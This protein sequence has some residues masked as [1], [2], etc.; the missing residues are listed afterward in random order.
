LATR[1]ILFAL[2]VAI[3]LS[4]VG[5]LRHAHA[6]ITYSGDI[7]GG[8]PPVVSDPNTWTSSTEAYIGNT[9]DGSIR[10]D[11][12]SK[13]VSSDS[14]L[15][16]AARCRGE[17]TVDGV[18]S[19]WTSS[20]RIKVGYGGNGVLNV[21]NGGYV[22]DVSGYVGGHFSGGAGTGAA[23]VSGAYSTW[24]NS[25]EL[26]VGL[27]GNGTLDI[28][29]GGNVSNAAGY[30]GGYVTQNSGVSSNATGIVTVAGAGSTWTNSSDLFVGSS[31][32]GRLNI[33][34]GGAVNS[35]NSYVGYS[36]VSTGVVTVD[37][38]GSTWNH[39]NLYVGAGQSFPSLPPTGGSG[40]LEITNGGRV[41][42]HAGGYLGYLAGSTGE[43]DVKG[44]GSKWT[45]QGDTYVGYGGNG[46]LNVTDGG[47]ISSSSNTSNGYIGY[48]AG[49]TG[50]VTLNG[51]AS[52][53]TR[54]K[55]CV[56]DAGNGTLNIK[57]GSAVSTQNAYIGDDSTS[58]GLVTVD[59]TG[60]TWNQSA[61]LY[62][63]KSGAGTLNITNGG[64]VAVGSVSRLVDSYIGSGANSSGVVT[65][66][67]ANSKWTNSGVLYVG[68]AGNGT[69]S[70][71][72]GGTVR[73]ISGGIGQD[74]DA[75]GI[76][77]VSG[78]GS[79]WTN[80]N[81]LHVG[82]YGSGA[83][84]VLNGGGVSNY[85]GYIG[86]YF[87]GTGVATVDGAGSTW[88]NAGALDVG[89]MGS[90]TLNVTNHGSV[91]AISDTRVAGEG[92]SAT[93]TINFGANGG[94]LTTGSLLASPN[95]L[96]GVGT[97][98]T[99]GLV[100]DV[101]LVFDSAAS[102]NQTL[103]LSNSG[104][105]VA[106]N[107]NMA[108]APS[109]NGALGAGYLGGGSLT[110]KN[111]AAVQSTRGYLGYKSGST[112]AAT[113]A[114]ANSTWANSSSLRVG[115][116]GS[117]QLTVTNGGSVSN[118]IGWVGFNPM[119]M[120]TVTVNGAGST[121]TNTEAL[122]VG[123]GGTG[124]LRIADGGMVTASSASINSSSLL[125]MDV[126]RGSLLSV[127]NGTSTIT[128]NGT[129]RVVAGAGIGAGENYSPIS[130]SSWTGTGVYQAIG[131]TWNA[132]DHTFTASAVKAG[133]SG[134]AVTVN[135]A[136]QQRALIT[137]STTRWAAG[138]S[139]LAS[140][141]PSSF[142]FTATTVTGDALNL[143]KNKLGADNAVLSAWNFLADGYTV[144]ETNPVY[145]SLK[146]GS[147][148]SADDL[149]LWHYDGSAWTAYSPLDLTYDG[150][151]ASFT[152]TSFSGYAVSGLA[153]PEPS[154]IALLFAAA[155]GLA[156]YARWRC[157][158]RRDGSQ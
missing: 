74:S 64:S 127:G 82:L 98:N 157:Q 15:G 60:S 1:S 151:Y 76:A 155:A 28:T 123:Y 105:N 27:L 45:T 88:T 39:G 132:T 102:L 25:S 108:T 53:W 11:S 18:G 49:S 141:T 9:A 37:G 34:S 147:G 57:G 12:K 110:V 54:A 89:Y 40:R 109:T 48:S 4:F 70:I 73:S 7:E 26:C 118:T 83:L 52:P 128:N 67:G 44:N 58:T 61:E 126:G 8:Y 112:G 79:A 77:T 36:T 116:Y 94:T 120:G 80:Q 2:A 124:T 87:G 117:G 85:C 156:G 5:P 131:G 95:Q 46:T 50:V 136:D 78:A 99:R 148:R 43:I 97:I 143:L 139:F 145:L 91:T 81:D 92:S 135:L 63:G 84:N 22:S 100:S 65:V 146:V 90:G 71:S 140:A 42:S 115:N 122:Y 31:A 47:C 69:L 68:D 33:R 142:D 158:S 23:T 144:S 16:Y 138:A 86:S 21:T 93:G 133:A 152:V 111:G 20:L 35:G 55:L 130:A 72:S 29:N 104:Q 113:V 107:F 19:T 75:T 41:T 121:W 24:T 106:I 17:V 101:D 149:D 134:T 32:N 14:H 125:A 38:I 56:G 114:G 30:V 137:D 96:T 62:V 59:G 51:S 13:L 129:V 150:A 119:S 153:V 3:V 10:V 6:A 154:A 103:T 66:D